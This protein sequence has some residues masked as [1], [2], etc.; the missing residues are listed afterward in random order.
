MIK[1]RNYFRWIILSLFIFIV[2][3]IVGLFAGLP[4]IPWIETNY[5]V[6]GT[7]ER[8]SNG[9]TLQ[10][11]NNAIIKVEIP[12][13]F[14]QNDQ[15]IDTW[16]T[17]SDSSNNLTINNFSFEMQ[18]DEGKPLTRENSYLFWDDGSKE[19]N[20]TIENYTILKSDT[21]SEDKYVFLRTVYNLDNEKEVTVKLKINYQLNRKTIVLDKNLQLI[22]K[23][24]LTWNEFRVH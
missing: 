20:L 22:K 23:Q 1:S 2:I 13:Y 17:S 8:L 10:Q 7:N 14:P 4:I 6:K 16:F 3:Y 5:Y 15:C 11:I 19:N 18:S 12:D 24:R 21:S 9:I